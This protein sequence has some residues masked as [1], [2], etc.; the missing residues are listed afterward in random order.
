M[1]I[2]LK[3][4]NCFAPLKLKDQRE[5]IVTCPYCDSENVLP[6]TVKTITRVN[7]QR[8]SSLLYRYIAEEFNMTG[9][10]D[11]IM[12]LNGRLQHASVDF[13]DLGGNDRRMKAM[14]LV[15]WCQRRDELDTLTAVVQAERPSSVLELQQS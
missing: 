2:Q 9:I 5:L 7:A 14:E 10:Q 6:G 12:K 11:L 13:D 4:Q 1:S 3:C 15:K 8:F